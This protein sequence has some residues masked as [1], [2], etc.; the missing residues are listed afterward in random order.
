MDE[1]TRNDV[2][3]EIGKIAMA[4]EQDTV[5]GCV[6]IAIHKNGTSSEILVPPLDPKHIEKLMFAMDRLHFRAQITVYLGPK[7]VP[8][9]VTKQ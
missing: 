3:R 8:P 6:L 5:V 4:V 2:A 9:G 1:L 7:A